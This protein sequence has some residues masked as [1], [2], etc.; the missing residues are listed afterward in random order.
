M[1]SLPLRFTGLLPV[2]GRI[3][4]ATLVGAVTGSAVIGSDDDSLLPSGIAVAT[5]VGCTIGGGI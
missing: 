3:G 5:V 1:S 2:N 4:V